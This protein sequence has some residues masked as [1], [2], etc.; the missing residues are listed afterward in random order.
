MAKNKYNSQEKSIWKKGFFAGLFSAKKK[1]TK[2]VS[3]TK[4]QSIKK[5]GGNSVLLS[6]AEDCRTAGLGAMTYNGKIYDVNFKGK[7]S[8]ITKSQIADMRVE[9]GMGSKYSDID[10]AERYTQHM[11]RKFGVFDENDKFLHML[12]EK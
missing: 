2:P 11:R 4:K 6:L 3:S 5:K 12:S 10:V 7:P 1:K 9:Y 8:L